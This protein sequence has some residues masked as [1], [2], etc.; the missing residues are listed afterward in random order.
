LAVVEDRIRKAVIP[1]AGLGTRLLP[2][3]RAIPKEMLP[4]GERPVIHHVVEELI[5]AGIEQILIVV[6]ARKGAIL[7]YFEQEPD[8]GARLY[9]VR[10]A[11]QRGL[12]DAV[13]LAEDFA[14]GEPV[15]VAL[16]DSIIRSVGTISVARRMMELHAAQCAGATIAVEKVPREEICRYGIV[17]PMGVGDAFPIRDHVDKP[18]P[19]PAPS[20]LAVAAPYSLTPAIL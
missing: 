11:E 9:Y 13:A 15:F 14:G 2:I 8:L 19:D 7:D 10:Q 18:D 5:E 4:V 3:T 6:S 12:A 16:G 20:D 1:A 17:E